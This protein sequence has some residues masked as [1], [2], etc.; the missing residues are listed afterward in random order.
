MDRFPVRDA[1]CWALDRA[2]LRRLYWSL[3]IYRTAKGIDDAANHC[4]AYRHLHDA[5][6]ALYLVALLDLYIAAEDDGADA[7]LLEVQH[8]AVYIISEIEQL[9]RHGLLESMDMG[10]AVTDCYNRANIVN[11]EVHIVVLNLTFYDGGYFFR[12]HLHN[13]AVT[14]I[15]FLIIFPSIM[16]MTVQSRPKKLVPE[17][18][19]LRCKAAVD[20]TVSYLEND[21]ADHFRIEMRTYLYLLAG[22]LM[23]PR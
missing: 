1:R 14:P 21:A 18:L 16:P 20:A 10:D 9:A 3:A 19:E 6:R 15:H 12:I 17:L 2:R 11:I 23:D 7:V 22:E 8:H 13:L 4:L 5:S